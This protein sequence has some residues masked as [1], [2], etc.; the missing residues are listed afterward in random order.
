MG[1]GY[2]GNQGA[3]GRVNPEAVCIVSLRSNN[4]IG[5]LVE[6]MQSKRR[7]NTGG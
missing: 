6:Y 7:G 4:P 5:N 1:V 2:G 3:E